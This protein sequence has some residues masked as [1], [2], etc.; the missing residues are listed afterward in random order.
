MTAQVT[1]LEGE[2]HYLR[3]LTAAAQVIIKEQGDKAKAWRVE[4]S[5]MAEFTSN[6]LWDI[7]RMY[8]RADGVANFHNTPQEV[9][10]FIR[11]CDVMLKEFKAHLKVAMDAP[12]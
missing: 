1:Q 9:L 12:L 4:Y 7:P 6:L 8:R 3:D 10:E 2:V 5:N 11:L